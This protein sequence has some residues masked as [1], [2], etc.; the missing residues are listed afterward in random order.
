M[1]ECV[2][3]DSRDLQNPMQFHQIVEGCE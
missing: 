1:R 2:R 3:F